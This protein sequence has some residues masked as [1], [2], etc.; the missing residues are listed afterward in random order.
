LHSGT[1]GTVGEAPDCRATNAKRSIDFQKKYT[2]YKD[3]DTPGITVQAI[4][5]AVGVVHG[6]IDK[7]P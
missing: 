6:A 2:I 5:S 1:D 7:E 4:L 3:L